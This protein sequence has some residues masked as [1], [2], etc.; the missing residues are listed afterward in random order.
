M[1]ITDIV[2]NFFTAFTNHEGELITDKRKIA[3]EYCT[4]WLFVD[5]ISVVPIELFLQEDYGSFNKMLKLLRIFKLLRVFRLVRI[6]KRI[7]A[8]YDIN[9][10]VLRLVQLFGALLIVWHWIACAYWTICVYEDFGKDAEG[11]WDQE[12]NTWMP[13]QLLWDEE[14][15]KSG[16]INMGTQYAAAFFWAVMVTTG[17]G[18]D[19][20]P[21]IGLMTVFPM[22]FSLLQCSASLTCAH[23]HSH[24]AVL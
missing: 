14:Y 10:S 1:F 8:G 11:Q 7:S 16:T 22:H 5:T 23:S 15:E 2:L 17:I 13:I 9:P 21:V 4:G 6:M 19:I 3:A 20:E 24:C 18:R 12:K